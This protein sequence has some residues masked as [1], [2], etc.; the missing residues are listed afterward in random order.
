MKTIGILGCGWLGQKLFESLK[1]IYNTKCYTRKDIKNSNSFEALDTLIVSINTKDN[2]LSTLTKVLNLI[3][4]NT[5]LILMS[6]ISVYREYDCEVDETATIS[7]IKLQ[8]EAEILLESTNTDVLILR[9][10]GLMG[11]DR[12]AGRWSKVS[13]FSDGYVNY[14]HRDDVI[15]IV[16]KLLKSNTTKGIYNLV[17]PNH[18]MRSE[19]HKQNAK[20]FGF[21]LGSFDGMTKRVVKSDKIIKDLEYKFLYPNPLK[22]W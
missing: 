1:N 17:A 11:Y 18:P 10:G 20:N 19:V 12:V 5:N 9:L 2:Y 21:K 13:K 15:E 14:I 7:E 4:K 8:R 6:S 16:K 22:F 3:D